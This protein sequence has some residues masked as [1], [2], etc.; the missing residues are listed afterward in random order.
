[1]N[2]APAVTLLIVALLLQAPA[3]KFVPAP[4]EPS[5]IVVRLDPAGRMPPGRNAT[6]PVAAGSTLLLIDQGGE[7]W[8]WTGQEAVRIFGPADVPAGL[9][10]VGHERILNVAAT[11]SGTTVYVM[12]I[13]SS[14]PPKVPRRMSPRDPDAWYVLYAFAFDGERLTSPRPITAM[15]VRTEGHTGGGLAVLPDGLVLF[16]PG[17]NG[18]SY[19][20]GRAYSQDPSVHL[21][22]LVSID[23][24][25]G[26]VAI[27]ALG[28][29]SAQRLVVTG[30]GAD[31]RVSFVDPGGWVAEELNSFLV[32]DW[33]SSQSRMNFGW[34]RAADGR[35]REGAFYLD[36]VGNSTALIAD[37]ERDFR[38][39]VASFGRESSP[40]VAVSGPIVGA[41]SFKRITALFGDLVSGEIFAVTGSMAETNHPVFRVRLVDDHGESATLRG[42]SGQKRPDPRFFTFPDGAAGVLIEAT[43]QFYRLVE[44]AK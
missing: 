23:P 7:L 35:A 42:L 3:Q 37:L 41:A 22:K 4:I 31:T 19:E 28:V 17:D 9:K 30:S 26:E 10:L 29:R 38:A 5:D 2:Y 24:E 34:G 27:M 36:P 21:S 40:F 14:V 33:F 43:G 1:M 11:P 32:R 39:P 25:T 13:S 44:H 12:F 18:D 15:Q 6:S 20:D 8:R 16:A